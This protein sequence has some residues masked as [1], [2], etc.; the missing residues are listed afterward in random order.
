MIAENLKGRNN[1]TRMIIHSFNMPGTIKLI[2]KFGKET[3]PVKSAYYFNSEDMTRTIDRW[4]N[5][6]K[7]RFQDF[8][9]HVKPSLTNLKK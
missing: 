6:Y 9:I 2:R 5:I 1:L 4:R 8:H 7:H 3:R